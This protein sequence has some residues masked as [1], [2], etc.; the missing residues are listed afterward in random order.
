M[1]TTGGNNR[2]RVADVTEVTLPAAFSSMRSHHFAGFRPSLNEGWV[3]EMSSPLL[4]FNQETPKEESPR[5]VA[6]IKLRNKIVKELSL[7]GQLSGANK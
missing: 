5:T 3:N 7:P 1:M 2:N 6:R 4:A